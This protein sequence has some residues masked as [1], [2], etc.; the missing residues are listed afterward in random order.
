[1]TAKQFFKA[2][3]NANAAWQVGEHIF[4]EQYEASARATAQRLGL[5]CKKLTREGDKK[6]EQ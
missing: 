3:P 1:M 2:Y 4:F 6:S 5:E